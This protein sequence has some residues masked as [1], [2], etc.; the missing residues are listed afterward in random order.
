MALLAVK[1]NGTEGAMEAISGY[2]ENFFACQECNEHF[3]AMVNS[4]ASK[5][6]VFILGSTTTTAV[7]LLLCQA[8]CFVNLT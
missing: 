1:L 7:D 6:D 3:G 2:A 5:D 8:R 4:T